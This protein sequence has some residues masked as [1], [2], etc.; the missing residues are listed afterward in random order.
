MSIPRESIKIPSDPSSLKINYTVPKAKNPNFAATKSGYIKTSTK[1]VDK[2]GEEYAVDVNGFQYDGKIYCKFGIKESTKFPGR[3]TVQV[4]LDEPPEVDES[5]PMYEQYEMQRSLRRLCDYY[6]SHHIQYMRDRDPDL[7]DDTDDRILRK[8]FKHNMIRYGTKDS[9]RAYPKMS[10]IVSVNKENNEKDGKIVGYKTNFWYYDKEREIKEELR[11]ELDAARE[12]ILA[13]NDFGD[14]SDELR[15][16]KVKQELA[17]RLPVKE[18]LARL[19]QAEVPFDDFDTEDAFIIRSCVF[20]VREFYEGN[21]D[22]IRVFLESARVEKATS[23]EPGFVDDG[24][25]LFD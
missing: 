16:I 10:L 8:D 18:R 9:D 22:G 2:D 3:V 14:L 23:S 7:K 6:N 4:R 12:E 19:K 24:D 13:E 17:K 25:N 5:D 20:S 1:K 15:E 21:G 11:A